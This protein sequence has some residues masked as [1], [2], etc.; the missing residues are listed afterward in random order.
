MR[1]IKDNLD[2]SINTILKNQEK[3]IKENKCY[4]Y[5]TIIIDIT[6][7]F[8]RDEYGANVALYKLLFNGRHYKIN[9][10][11]IMDPQSKS[12]YDNISNND[13]ILCD[14]T[15]NT[16]FFNGC[17]IELR[18]NFDYVFVMPDILDDTTQNILY[19]KYFNVYSYFESF[20]KVYDFVTKKGNVLT[21]SHIEGNRSCISDIINN[22]DIKSYTSTL[23]VSNNKL[24]K[25]VIKELEL[26]YHKF[27]K[28]TFLI[29]GQNN[30]ENALLINSMIHSIKENDK[31]TNIIEY[32]VVITKEN[33]SMYENLTE[34]IFDNLE[35]IDK[36]AQKEKN[37][38]PEERKNYMIVIEYTNQDMK[39]LE[40][41]LTKILATS[42]HSNFSL[43]L[44]CTQVPYGGL[45]SEFSYIFVNN[46]NDIIKRKLYEKIFD[47]FP[48]FDLFKY[49]YL[50]LIKS[51]DDYIVLNNNYIWKKLLSDK[52]Y[53]YKRKSFNNI[54]NKYSMIQFE[55]NPNNDSPE[56]DSNEL[57][58]DSKPDSRMILEKKLES[59]NNLIQSALYLLQQANKE[60]DEI[61]SLINQLI[62]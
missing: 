12:Q 26:T 52:I 1:Y 29:I 37:I 27:H 16:N 11:L 13:I 30:Q 34:S 62:K 19:E 18:Y 58:S 46:R 22:I 38:K 56:N 9:Y 8:V 55:F 25:L 15:S 17:S 33:K 24:D 44:A 23:N 21:I 41:I 14:K 3:L 28:N 4:T 48:Y 6:S 7:G 60:S 45:C 57:H 35:I 53:F 40:P 54:M 42:R 39:Q 43:I 5:P 50:A 36:I 32:V 31:N 2:L 47:C 10:I 49:V 59:H 51:P 20:K 61:K